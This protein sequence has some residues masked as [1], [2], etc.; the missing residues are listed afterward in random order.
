MDRTEQQAAGTHPAPCA[1]HCEANAFQIE[2]RGLKAAHASAVEAGKK[3][4]Q[5][6]LKAERERDAI[7]A[8]LKALREQEP[9]GYIHPRSYRW[10]AAHKASPSSYAATRIYCSETDSQTV[11]LY[12]GPVPA[13]ELT[14]EV[15]IGLLPDAKRLPAGWRDFARAIERHLLGGAA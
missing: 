7:A 5:Q 9:I 2:I 15:I 8:E 10:F 12:A 1:R 11:P 4:A 3:L 6:A 14:D 13:R